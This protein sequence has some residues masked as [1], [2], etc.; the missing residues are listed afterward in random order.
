M[1]PVFSSIADTS[2]QTNASK[3]WNCNFFGVAERSW[4]GLFFKCWTW[5]CA[6]RPWAAADRVLEWSEI[7]L[8]CLN[9]SGVCWL[10]IVRYGFL[11]CLWEKIWAVFFQMTLPPWPMYRCSPLRWQPARD[12]DSVTDDAATVRQGSPVAGSKGKKK[13]WTILVDR[14]S[15]ST[16]SADLHS[17]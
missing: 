16:S 14:L 11:E 3:P 10:N 4:R 13:K 7:C 1:W 8:N 15:S 6:R 9:R 5:N 17:H 12:L 2:D